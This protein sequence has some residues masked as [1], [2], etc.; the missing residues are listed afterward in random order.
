MPSKNDYAAGQRQFSKIAEFTISL[1]FVHSGKCARSLSN[2]D[3]GS[4]VAGK[5]AQPFSG[6]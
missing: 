5:D 3:D 1:I 6:F 2:S 4:R